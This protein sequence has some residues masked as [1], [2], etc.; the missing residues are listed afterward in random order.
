MNESWQQVSARVLTYLYY[1]WKSFGIWNNHELKKDRT[2]HHP[3]KQQPLNFAVFY[4][5]FQEWHH[6]L[7]EEKYFLKL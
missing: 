3:E 7:S 1:V 4:V 2:K 6:Q 5:N